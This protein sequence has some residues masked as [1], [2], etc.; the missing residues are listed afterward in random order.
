MSLQ[1][2]ICPDVLIFVSADTA[3]NERGEN[4]A[5]FHDFAPQDVVYRGETSDCRTRRDVHET[6]ILPLDACSRL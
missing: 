4:Y 6:V 3:T 2:S 1:L 5:C